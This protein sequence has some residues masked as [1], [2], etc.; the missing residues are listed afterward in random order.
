MSTRSNLH[1]LCIV[2]SLQTNTQLQTIGLGFN[3]F[4]F[5][6]ALKHAQ[7]FATITAK[8]DIKI[9]GK[10]LIEIE[11][12]QFKENY[13]IISP[14]TPYHISYQYYSIASIVQ[15]FTL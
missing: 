15:S 10:F 9:I 5:L 7:L 2:L 8:T 12:S 11:V 1:H 6:S 4:I 3:R 14:V 13:H